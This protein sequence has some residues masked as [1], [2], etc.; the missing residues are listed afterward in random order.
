MRARWVC[1]PARPS[2]TTSHRSPFRSAETDPRP[3]QDPRAARR[4]I[5][6]V[7][8]DEPRILHPAVGIFIGQPETGL[9]RLA[10]RITRQVQ[11]GGARQYPAPA[12]RIVHEKAEPDQPG[13]APPLHPRHHD[14]QEPRRGSIVLKS[15]VGR[16]GQ[17]EAHRPADMRHGDEQRLP[18]LQG[19]PHQMELEIFEVPQPAVEQ[20]GRSRGGRL[21]QIALLRQ[22]HG[23]GPPPPLARAPAPVDA[24]TDD[25]KVG[26]VR[27]STIR[28]AFSPRAKRISPHRMGRVVSTP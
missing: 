8:H 22:R 5:A 12:Q 20:L 16:I 21:R 3:R 26:N 25:E 2:V 1:R 10:G 14:P 4:R 28:Q 24:A 13:R 18:L 6:R 19:F 9:Q 23:K 15:H 7:Q 27:R 17:H 11:P